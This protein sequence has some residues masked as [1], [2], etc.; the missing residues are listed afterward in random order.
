MKTEEEIKK[1]A[2]EIYPEPAIYSVGLSVGNDIKRNAFIAGYKQYQ[3]DSVNMFTEE[4]I[5]KINSNNKQEKEDLKY[6]IAH[7][8]SEWMFD[9]G[10]IDLD[11]S[12]DE[13]DIKRSDIIAEEFL[14]SL[15][16]K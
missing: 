15:K 10:Y 4:D 11:N 14:Q 9:K 8:F 3:Q 12:P 13:D 16:N 1:L 5:K 6:L 2:K 7:I